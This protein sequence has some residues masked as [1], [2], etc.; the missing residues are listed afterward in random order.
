MPPES[1]PAPRKPSRLLQFFANIIPDEGQA[2]KIE[3]TRVVFSRL[4]AQL[5]NELPENAEKTVALRLL[6]ESKQAAVRAVLY[7]E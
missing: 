3:V 2:A 4:A 5:D 6:M 7:Q 1:V